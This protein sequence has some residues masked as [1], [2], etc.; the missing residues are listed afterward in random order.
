MPFDGQSI[1]RER[2]DILRQLCEAHPRRSQK[3]LETCLWSEARR[4]PRL[5]HLHLAY[6]PHSVHVGQHF[7]LMIQET[8]IVFGP[9]SKKAKLPIILHALARLDGAAQGVAPGAASLF[10]PR[11][12]QSSL[13]DMTPAAA[14]LAVRATNQLAVN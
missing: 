5:G 10:G 8:L 7:G 9:H 14:I 2:L 1:K 11:P 4:D 3:T 12:R 13:R 6:A